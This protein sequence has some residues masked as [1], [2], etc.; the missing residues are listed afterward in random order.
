MKFNQQLFGAA[1]PTAFAAQRGDV[2]AAFRE[3]PGLVQVARRLEAEAA[4]KSRGAMIGGNDQLYASMAAQARAFTDA[5]Q[6][7]ISAN[8][9]DGTYNEALSEQGVRQLNVMVSSSG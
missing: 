1:R 8:N 7:I 3:A 2:Q 6:L 9:G 4:R 5:A